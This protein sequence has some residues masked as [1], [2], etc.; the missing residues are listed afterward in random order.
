MRD[1]FSKTGKRA[2]VYSASSIGVELLLPGMSVYVATK[3]YNLA[4][5]QVLYNENRAHGVDF[6]G[7]VIGSVK[8]GM[9]R[10]VFPYTISA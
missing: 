8:T 3:A 6:H 2:A 9:N 7:S 5:S 1:R 4:F 10:G